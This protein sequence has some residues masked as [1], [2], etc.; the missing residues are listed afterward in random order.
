MLRGQ[1]VPRRHRAHQVWHR[2][3]RVR[4]VPSRPSVHERSVRAEPRLVRTEQLRRLLHR[5]DVHV[6][7]RVDRVR[8][9]RSEVLELQLRGRRAAVRRSLR[10]VQ[11]LR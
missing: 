3:S 4:R 7:R 5:V 8:Q 10:R 1:H 11:G 2:R 6:G 9:R